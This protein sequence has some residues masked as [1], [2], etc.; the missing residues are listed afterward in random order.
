[1][2]LSGEIELIGLFLQ[3]VECQARMPKPVLAVSARVCPTHAP[4]IQNQLSRGLS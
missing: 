3:L 4:M 2:G 1:M